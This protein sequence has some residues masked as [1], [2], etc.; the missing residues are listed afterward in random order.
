MAELTFAVSMNATSGLPRDVSLNV[1][2]YSVDFPDTVEGTCDEIKASYATLVQRLNSAYSGMTIRVY[3]QGGGAP[4]FTKTYAQ[5]FNGGGGPTEVALCLSYS[6]DDDAA[7]SKRRR[8]RIYLPWI[9]GAARPTTLEISAMLD[10][11]M[12]LAQ[13]GLAGNTT[14]KM[15]SKLGTGTPLNPQPVLRK[16]ESISCDNEWDTQRRRGLKATVRTRRDVQ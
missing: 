11:G 12:L 10:F 13:V 15:L 9:A 7:G 14:W 8:G 16:I 2:H 3:A 6:A 5:A 4:T 1:L